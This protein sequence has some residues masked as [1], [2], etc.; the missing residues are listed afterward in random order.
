MLRQFAKT[1]GC[2]AVMV[3]LAWGSPA[4][5]QDSQSAPSTKQRSRA[6]PGMNLKGPSAPNRLVVPGYWALGQENIQKEVGLTDDQKQKLTDISDR[7]QATLQR[8]LEQLRE[9][10]QQ[11]Q[12]SRMA[13]LRERAK[14][15]AQVARTKVE[16]VLTP[17]QVAALQKIDFRMRAP[18]LLTNPRSHEQ[19]GLSEEQRQRLR[20]IFDEAQEKLQKLQR[21]TADQALGLLSPDQVDK[22]RQQLDAQQKQ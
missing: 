19:L 18:A 8:G 7:Y 9:L 5:A 12:Q 22:L 1:L 3:A 21:E 20:K 4:W 11:E 13:E 15:L 16:S 2:F 6:L 17:Q 14:E 10:P